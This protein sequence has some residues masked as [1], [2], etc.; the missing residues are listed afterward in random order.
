[1]RKQKSKLLDPSKTWNFLSGLSSSTTK[2][3][4]T[5][6]T[7]APAAK[8]KSTSKTTTTTTTKKPTPV[9]KK[10]DG[11]K[12]VSNIS[13][14]GKSNN[15]QNRDLSR[16]YQ[17]RDLYQSGFSELSSGL[18]LNQGSELRLMI[19][20]SSAP[21]HHRSRLAIRQTWGHYSIRRDV[22]I[23]F[24]IGEDFKFFCEILILK[25]KLF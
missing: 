19:I 9:P 1:M 8:T 2:I 21:T 23:G 5:T 13:K 16:G 6:T 7:A 4:N 12:I 10:D 22:S 17:T 25:L 11:K 3:S 20:I 15:S 24:L 14:I 18:C